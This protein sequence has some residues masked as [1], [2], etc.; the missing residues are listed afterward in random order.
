MANYYDNKSISAW[1]NDNPYRNPFTAI[2][3]RAAPVMAESQ[4]QGIDW[5]SKKIK[6]SDASF[7]IPSESIQWECY[8]NAIKKLKAK[9]SR[10]FVLIG[11][12]NHYMH[13]PGSQRRLFSTIN[14]LK[15]N[16]DDM[17]IPYFDTL[18]IEIPSDNFADSCHLLK[19]GHIM[20]AEE[21]T[22]DAGFRK[23]LAAIE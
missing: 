4:G 19:D 16:L 12:Y 10:V 21:L 18:Q 20:L 22:K 7:V 11:P 6:L 3:F 8:L 13:T 23:W 1:I 9:N 2:T 5:I 17:K 15:K 14:I